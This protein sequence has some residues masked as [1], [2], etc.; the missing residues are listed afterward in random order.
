MWF[1]NNPDINPADND[2]YLFI[3]H[4]HK[5]VHK[6]H[7]KIKKNIIENNNNKKKQTKKLYNGRIA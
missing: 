6:V 2:V 3:Y 1:P 7:M 4:Y 5:F